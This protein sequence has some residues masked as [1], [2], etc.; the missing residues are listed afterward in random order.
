MILISGNQIKYRG[1]PI[2]GAWLWEGEYVHMYLG[3]P[4]Q[5]ILAIIPPR[6]DNRMLTSKRLFPLS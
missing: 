5:H 6:T 2:W 3:I 1:L 4:I